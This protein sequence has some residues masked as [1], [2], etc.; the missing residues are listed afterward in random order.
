MSNIGKQHLEVAKQ[1][2]ENV[3]T[4]PPS[5]LVRDL[6]RARRQLTAGIRQIAQERD[7]TDVSNTGTS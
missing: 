5:N 7:K 1:I 4:A 3:D 6:K 2:L